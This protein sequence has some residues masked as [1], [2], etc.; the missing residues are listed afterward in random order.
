ME[1]E[2]RK[3]GGE[4]EDGKRRPAQQTQPAGGLPLLTW[5]F[6][7][8]YVYNNPLS[9]PHFL[10]THK[11]LWSHGFTPF[12]TVD[13]FIFFKDNPCGLSVLCVPGP[14]HYLFYV[15][16]SHHYHIVTMQLLT[17]TLYYKFFQ[18]LFQLMLKFYFNKKGMLRKKK[19][20]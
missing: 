7:L 10:S 4:G 11:L 15:N 3:E 8:A 6:I 18:I 9:R 17:F 12:L 5:S 14:P 2:R 20:K 19:G 13:Q 1:S 16:L